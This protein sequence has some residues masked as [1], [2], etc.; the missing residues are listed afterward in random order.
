[1]LGI[2]SL[3]LAALLTTRLLE[4]RI[5]AVA[6]L[7][8]AIWVAATT[9]YGIVYRFRNQ[10]KRLSAVMHT[11]AAFWGMSIAHL[12]L[13]VFTVGVALTSIYTQEQTV[14]MAVNDTH[15]IGGYT[16]TFDSIEDVRGPNY[17]AAE[18]IFSVERDGIDIGTIATQKRVY[19]VRRDGMT[20]AGIDAGFT[21][22]LFIAM[23]EPLNEGSAWSVRIQT[24]PFIRW[25]WMGTVFM[26]FGGLLAAVDRRYRRLAVR[27]ST[28]ERKPVRER[29]PEKLAGGAAFAASL[30]KASTGRPES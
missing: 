10:R 20:E 8:L 13:A 2:A 17:S 5:S 1:M 15:T 18:A 26:A 4:Y 3:V 28:A 12:G 24:K 25:I 14:R 11:P 21:R 22:D 19:D 6:T 30:G 23:G 9:I 7:A 29:G 16:F 27:Q